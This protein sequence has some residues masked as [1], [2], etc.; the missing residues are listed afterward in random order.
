MRATIIHTVTV[1]A[2]GVD[3]HA[4]DLPYKPT[5]GSPGYDEYYPRFK[6]VRDWRPVDGADPDIS[7]RIKGL[8]GVFIVVEVSTPFSIDS[9]ETVLAQ[10]EKL[11]DIAV[12][13]AREH[14]ALG[15]REEFSFYCFSGYDDIDR[16]IDEH[17]LLL[18]QLLRD[19]TAIL[20][21]TEIDS[22]LAGSVRYE[23]DDLVV[24]DWDGAA[25]FDM[26]GEFEDDLA[27][28][29]VANVQILS[30]RALDDEL[31]R[32]LD[33]FR[34][35]GNLGATGVWRLSNTLSSIV[36]TRTTSLLELDAIDNAMKLY[37]EWYDARVYQLAVRK[38]FIERWR[39]TVGG[40]LSTLEKMFEMVSTRQGEIY[41][42]ILEI[43]IV[44]LIVIEIVLVLTGHA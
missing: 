32:E 14:G 17:R 30:L 5:K 26:E 34:E 25:L 41:N 10:K 16:F 19:E 37:G 24:V 27:L 15:L 28:L 35:Q 22:T 21:D 4:P 33:R 6:I 1:I 42:I 29:E 20:T 23:A 18:T 9:A 43:T 39:V 40:K 38:L 44:V 8:R 13:V 11:N 36:A 12:S 31:T 3:P 2:H 7:A